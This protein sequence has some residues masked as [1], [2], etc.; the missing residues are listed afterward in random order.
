MNSVYIDHVKWPYHQQISCFC[1]KL[2]GRRHFWVSLYLLSPPRLQQIKCNMFSDEKV[3]DLYNY[4]DTNFVDDFN[5]TYWIVKALKHITQSV[6]VSKYQLS[7]IVN[8]I[9]WVFDEFDICAL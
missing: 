3:M 5:F 1:W 8:Y 9:L 4:L 6:I 7:K 2:E